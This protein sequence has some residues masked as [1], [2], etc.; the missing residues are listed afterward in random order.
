MQTGEVLRMEGFGST[1]SPGDPVLPARTYEIAVPPNIDWKTLKL[2]MEVS[3]EPLTGSHDMLPAPPAFARVGDETVVDWG[4]GKDIRA[5]RNMNVYGQD[6]FF[7]DEPLRIVAQAQARKWRFVKVEFVPVQYNPVRRTLRL[8]NS[9]VVHLRFMRIGRKAFRSDPLLSDTVMD[10]EAAKRF[11][12]FKEAM[13]WYRSP[14][15]ALPRKSEADYVIVTTNAIRDHSA[16]L[17]GFVVHK[18]ALG[19]TVRIVTENEYG[20][21]SGAGTDDKIRQWLIDNYV[22]LGIRF[23]LLIGDPD[24]DDPTDPNDPV[25]S[26]PMKMCWPH[27]KEPSYRES[28][29]DY[30]F[31]DLTGNWDFDGDGLFGEGIP[32]DNS[33]SPAAGIEPD[34]FSAWWIGRLQVDV[35]GMTSFMT[36]SDDGIRVFIDGTPVIDD[37]IGHLPRVD[38]GS[39]TLTAGQHDVRIEYF[40]EGGDGMAQLLWEPPGQAYYSLVPSQQLLHWDGSSYVSGGLFGSYFNNAD[41]TAPVIARLDQQINFFWGTGDLG[42]GGVDF[43][44]EVFVGRIPVYGGDYATLDSILSKTIAYETGTSPIS[45]RRLLFAAVRL[46]P[47]NP[48]ASDYQLGEALKGVATGLGFS[49]YR[50]YESDFGIVPPPECPAINPRSLDPAAPCNMLG[51]W[52]NGGGAGL[53]VWSTHGWVWSASGLIASGDAAGLHD[54]TPAFTFQG[55]CMNGYPESPTNLG[56]SLLKQGAIATVSASRVSWNRVF[57]PPIDPDPF[58]GSNANL[59]YHYA[60]RVMQG[61]PAANALYKTMASVAQPPWWM[62]QMDFNLYGDPAVT[63]GLPAAVCSVGE[64][65][66]SSCTVNGQQGIRTDHCVDGAWVHGACVVSTA[67]THGEERWK[68][69]P[70]NGKLGWR[71]ELCLNGVWRKSS[72]CLPNMP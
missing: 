22:G 7:P 12:N 40:D 18:T 16:R 27:T 62:N 49:T 58:S 20:E 70:L 45:R 63:L 25:G 15:N 50:I 52:A 39:I 37:W 26:I 2:V 44:P 19:Y 3:T 43:E 69:C 64:V 4:P 11:I 35:A 21:L 67:C 32:L 30:F 6:R 56:F 72:G 59:A 17:G 8:V 65:R 28:P 42:A 66:H 48:A 38:T 57:T 34:T 36:R 31:A 41:F 10:E 51:R 54:E 23:V 61:L 13:D 5:G 53:V 46:D 71:R 60:L 24:P 29:T 33:T 68:S 14:P 1:G 9:V 55:S 47:G